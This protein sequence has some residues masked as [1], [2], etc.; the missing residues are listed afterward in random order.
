MERF[1]L[2]VDRLIGLIECLYSNCLVG[3]AR[4]A[5]L[6]VPPMSGSGDRWSIGALGVPV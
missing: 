4:W 3:A 6:T 5:L 2:V 1:A